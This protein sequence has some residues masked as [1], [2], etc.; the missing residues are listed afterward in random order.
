MKDEKDPSI[1]AQ[2]MKNIEFLTSQVKSV[3]TKAA[4]VFENRQDYKPQI[5]TGSAAAVGILVAARRGR[6][7]GAL[8]GALAGVGTASAVNPNTYE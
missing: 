5:V 3:A 8:M 2:S 1:S 7:P 6:V 4:F